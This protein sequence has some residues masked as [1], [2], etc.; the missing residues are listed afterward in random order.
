M[1]R[2][3]GFQTKPREVDPMAASPTTKP[4]E[5]IP[6]GLLDVLQADEI[7]DLI[8]YLKSGPDKP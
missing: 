3:L 4:K 2:V 1:L 6:A 7:L 5:L 8:A